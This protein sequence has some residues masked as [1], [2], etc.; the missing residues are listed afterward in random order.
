M[1][2]CDPYATYTIVQSIIQHIDRL[3]KSEQLPRV[4]KIS[5]C[6]RGNQTITITILEFELIWLHVKT[7]EI[8]FLG[9]SIKKF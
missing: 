9:F 1:I 8:E 7:D 6:F 5:G 2:L 3:M 4:S